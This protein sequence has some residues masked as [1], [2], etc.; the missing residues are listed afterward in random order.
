M[1]ISTLGNDFQKLLGEYINALELFNTLKKEGDLILFG[2]AVRSYIDNKFRDLPRD[3]DIVINKNDNH[4]NLDII[5]D[6]F[7]YE[8]NRFGGYKIKLDSLEF[9]I[10]EIEKTWAFK[11]NKINARRC[12]YEESLPK[13]VFLNI[14]SII[15]NLNTNNY[16]SEVYENAMNNKILDV[17][18]EEN[19]YVEL[20]LLR[21]ILFKRKYNMSFSNRLNDMFKKFVK[22][23][24]NYLEILMDIQIK[25]YNTLK[26]S[27]QSLFEE[28]ELILSGKIR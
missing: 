7:E 17:V 13:T 25:H 18:L 21:A 1:S 8:K 5:L 27:S 28:I 24:K 10:W 6:E 22:E 14:D 23:N 9:D 11:E 3:F 26:I 4:T 20:N 19:P 16:Y 15:Y 12:V 2:G